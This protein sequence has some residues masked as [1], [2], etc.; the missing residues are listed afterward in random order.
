MHSV[1]VVNKPFPAPQK[2]NTSVWCKTK[3]KT[4]ESRGLEARRMAETSDNSRR[5]QTW[6]ITECSNGDVQVLRTVKNGGV[7]KEYLTEYLELHLDVLYAILSK[8]L[9]ALKAALA[10]KRASEL[11]RQKSVLRSSSLLRKLA[12]CSTTN[13][14]DST[15]MYKN[16]EI[17]NLILGLGLG[18]KRALFDEGCIYV[19]VL[20]L[21]KV[22]RGKQAYYCYDDAE[23]KQLQSSFPS[24]A[25][26]NI[27]RFG[28]DD[29]YTIMGNNIGSRE[30]TTKAINGRGCSRSECCFFLSFGFLEVDYRNELIQSFASMINLDQHEGYHQI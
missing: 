19:G 3:H 15:A 11:V 8:S 23:L 16:E 5:T 10:A 18:V 21:Y 27:Q 30:K 22:E 4:V 2:Q 1:E 24:N 7:Y 28:R 17:Q 29:A 20:P 12:D 6:M 9:N 13:P 26:Y 14:G 25:S